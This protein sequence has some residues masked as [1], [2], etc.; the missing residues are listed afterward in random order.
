VLNVD[1]YTPKG[2]DDPAEE[3][4]IREELEHLLACPSLEATRRSR[5]FLRYIVEKTLSDSTNEISQYAI[6]TQVFGRDGTF[7]PT[8]DPA[9][10]IEAGR[11]RRS[12]K[13]YYADAGADTPVRIRL[14]KGTYIPTFEYRPPLSESAP[15]DTAKAGPA[16]KPG[17]SAHNGGHWPTVVVMPITNL[18][19]D[20]QNDFIATGLTT[21]LATELSRYQDLR[22][23][24]RPA[25]AQV[26][27]PPCKEKG[28]E[29][30]CFV[31]EGDLKQDPTEMKV[32]IR[33]LNGVSGA[34]VWSESFRCER[35]ELHS[36]RFQERA[37]ES[38]AAHI[39]DEQG[40]LARTMAAES[41]HKPF[42]DLQ[43]YE[44]ILRYH[45]FEATYEPE[46]LGA[47]LAAL[48]NAVE[49]GPQCGLAWA[50]LARTYATNYGIEVLDEDTPIQHALVYAKKA[51]SLLPS[52]QRTRYTLALVHLLTGE[53]VA[54]KEQVLR[55]LELNPGSIML[56]DGAGYILTLLG[57]WERGPALIREAIEANPYHRPIVRQGLWLAHFRLKQYEAAYEET[58]KIMLPTLFWHHL[59]Q[60]TTLGHLG[61]ID[62]ARDCVQRMLELKPDF[63]ER[64]P[65]LI[66]NYIRFEGIAQ[67]VEDGLQR[68]GLALTV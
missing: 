18:T 51:V 67:R 50:M 57:D 36:L 24:L 41:A 29:P 56:M 6:A 66:R 38:V 45:E 47:A 13:C 2:L 53:L 23:L 16:P 11:L 26:T 62:K 46:A 55:G 34:L 48:R 43:A 10:R 63:P 64:G 32:S 37:A 21:E 17:K 59:T 22:V 44:A 7:D 65:V 8:I 54:G 15:V 31:V 4:V 35:Q 61:Q 39:A 25:Q 3:A 58:R 12:L 33:V 9:V 27:A 28:S 19:G 30:P 1:G 49:V 60:A 14:P 40:I 20:S 5:A 52:N 42:A 68:A